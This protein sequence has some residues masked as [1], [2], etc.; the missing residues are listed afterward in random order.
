MVYIITLKEAIKYIQK[1]YYEVLLKLRKLENYYNGENEILNRKSRPNNGVTNR[2]P[3]N[4]AEYISN[5]TSNY[6]MGTPIDYVCPSDEAYLEIDKIM[7]DNSMSAL[8]ADLALDMSIF[9]KAYEIAYISETG[10]LEFAQ[11]NTK[12]VIPIYNQ[13]I[14]PKLVSAIV[15]DIYEKDSTESTLRLSIYDETEVTIYETSKDLL[16]ICN[17]DTLMLDSTLTLIDKRPHLIGQC[18]VLEYK[19]NKYAKGD[20]EKVIPLIDAYDMLESLSLDDTEDFTNAYL[21]LVNAGDLDSDVKAAIRES[22]ILSFDENGKAEWLIKEINDTFIENLKQRI[23]RDIHK[24]TGTLDMSDSS[25]YQGVAS[26]VALKWRYSGLELKRKEKE[27]QYRVSLLRRLNII[28]DYLAKH[29]VSVDPFEI[30]IRFSISITVNEIEQVQMA[31]QS[32]GI[33]SKKTQLSILPF[34]DDIE[35]ELDRLEEEGSSLA[36]YP[37]LGG[38]SNAQII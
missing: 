16:T 13:D 38:D 27:R 6:F 18:P 20:F 35:A 26:G 22:K 25:L 37:D 34:V 11:L 17:P 33:V 7:R 32:S 4:F 1:H 24:L 31:V 21:T 9:G 36:S 10:M 15:Y 2:I 8:D 28:K 29:N 14:K 3:H 19:N 12:R 30:E 23:N 5:Q